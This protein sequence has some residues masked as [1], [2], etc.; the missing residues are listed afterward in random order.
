[1]A[2]GQ[3]GLIAGQ[4][5]LSLA[6]GSM[7]R[8]RENRRRDQRRDYFNNN[9]RGMLEDSYDIEEPDYNEL[10]EAE[11]FSARDNFD[12]QLNQFT[13]QTDA[14]ESKFGFDNS[15]FTARTRTEGL[16]ALNNNFETQEFNIDRSI[17][18]I[19]SQ[20]QSMI[21]NNKIRA[22]EMEYQYLYG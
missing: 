5:L 6:Q 16:E 14:Q 17:A 21:Q 8:R 20:M 15:G 10:R 4:G 9:L 7:N 1:M 19:Q 22:K 13:R 12:N 11:L 3:V 18:D 2:W